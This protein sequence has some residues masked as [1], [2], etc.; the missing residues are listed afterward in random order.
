MVQTLKSLSIQIIETT[1]TN[2][3]N[4]WLIEVKLPIEDFK[5]LFSNSFQE[6]EEAAA[7]E[8]FKLNNEGRF[9]EEEEFEEEEE[10][11]EEVEEVEEP[12]GK[13]KANRE[14]DL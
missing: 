4:V 11:L 2:L 3:L 10:E 6:A 14:L 5:F 13:K 1:T 8:E 12:F 9:I 7:M